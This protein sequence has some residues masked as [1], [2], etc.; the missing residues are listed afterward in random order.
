MSKFDLIDPILFVD[1]NTL[2]IK[3]QI[4]SLTLY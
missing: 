4:V 2:S 3:L 1:N